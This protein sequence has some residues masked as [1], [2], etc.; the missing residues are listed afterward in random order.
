M[1]QLEL[2]NES[3]QINFLMERKKIAAQVRYG[4]FGL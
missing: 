2:A 1:S 4:V 3:S